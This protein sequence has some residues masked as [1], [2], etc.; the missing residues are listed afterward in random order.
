LIGAV[1][2]A[3]AS[4][5]L[6]IDNRLPELL[7]MSA[8]IEACAQDHA[9]SQIQAQYIDLCATELVTNV[10]DY[11]FEDE[12]PHPIAL[13]LHID[14]ARITLEIEDDGKPF[15]PVETPERPR[16]TDLDK[17]R[18]GG[19]GIGIVRHFADDMRYCR[20]DGRNRL[21]VVFGR[22]PRSPQ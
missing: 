6:V 10:I 19:W 9:V 7:R 3:A 20:A 15:D 18:V 5:C 11:G 8:W 14:D 22:E 21:T 1:C 16:S 2:P 12:A 17:G 13:H 4:T